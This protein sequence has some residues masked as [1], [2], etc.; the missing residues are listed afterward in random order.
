MCNCFWSLV[1]SNLLQPFQHCT[2][3]LT[4]LKSQQWG[5]LWVIL[6]EFNMNSNYLVR[7]A[8]RN[9]KVFSRYFQSRCKF[10]IGFRAVCRNFSNI[11]PSEEYS[12]VCIIGSGPAGFYTAQHI[13][14]VKEFRFLLLSCYL[15]KIFTS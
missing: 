1:T 15:T 12:Q 7:F 5:F 10:Y 11:A 4:L 9:S 3:Y 2:K 8:K 14:K 6:W 13:L